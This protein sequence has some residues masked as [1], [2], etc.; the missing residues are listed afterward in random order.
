MHCMNEV[1]RARSPPRRPPGP[2]GR[3]LRAR[4]WLRG[5]L[6]VRA[7]VAATVRAWLSEPSQPAGQPGRLPALAASRPPAQL[8]V[9]IPA[10]QG[11]S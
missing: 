7:C 5:W 11:S 10:G 1:T 2:P 8:E 3:S 9:K 6:C 4:P